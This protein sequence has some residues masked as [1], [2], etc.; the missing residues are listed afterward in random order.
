MMALPLSHLSSRERG[1]IIIEMAILFPIMAIFFLGLL[2]LSQ[3]FILRERVNKTANNVATALA[4]VPP[5]MLPG[6]GP[7]GGNPTTFLD[8]SLTVAEPFNSFSMDVAF[9]EE[10]A[11]Q[12][13]KNF[14]PRPYSRGGN[15]CNNTGALCE[16]SGAGWGAYVSVR[17]CGVF[18][19]TVVPQYFL[20]TPE[21]SIQTE[22]PFSYP[23]VIK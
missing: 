18:D 7:N 1:S 4:T 14:F 12:A 9:C 20:N 19:P 17:V 16:R 10:G 11:E 22:A 8:N 2:E 5:D 21:V 6:S 13:S 23:N 3:Y 15:A